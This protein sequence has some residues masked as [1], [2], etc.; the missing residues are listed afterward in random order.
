[1]KTGW[2]NGEWQVLP[3]TCASLDGH[4]AL[5]MAH[6]GTAARALWLLLS[7]FVN[8]EQLV[9]AVSFTILPLSISD[10]NG[11]I[12]REVYFYQR[13]WSLFDW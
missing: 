4:W 13:C 6:V 12:H 5:Q 10:V 1:M 9:D 7:V 8:S 11:L 3:A 2:V